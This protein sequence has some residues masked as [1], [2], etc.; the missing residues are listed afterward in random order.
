ML[1]ITCIRICVIDRGEWAVGGGGGHHE[2]PG[3]LRRQVVPHAFLC[4]IPLF[5][6]RFALMIL[7]RYLCMH[8][9]MTC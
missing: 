3:A 5:G 8:T 7:A 2:A 4:R 6:Q 1:W 9:R